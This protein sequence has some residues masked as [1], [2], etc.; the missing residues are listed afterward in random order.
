MFAARFFGA[1]FFAPRYWGKAGAEILTLTL[2]CIDNATA[3]AAIANTA[4]VTLIRNRAA[5]ATIVNSL[6]CP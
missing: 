5:S 3:S 6:P 4:A 2:A 1:R